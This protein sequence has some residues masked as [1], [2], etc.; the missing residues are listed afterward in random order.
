MKLNEIKIWKLNILDITILFVLLLCLILFFTDKSKATGEIE[1]EQNQVSKFSYQVLIS[2]VSETTGEVIKEGDVLFDKVT[3]APMGTITKI[4]TT[5]AIGFLK[6][7]QGEILAKEIPDKI[8]L[9]LTVETDGN[10]KDGE[11]YANNLVRILVGG[12]KQLKTKYAM[13]IGEVV[14][15]VN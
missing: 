1:S 7:N 5:G 2:G 9:I 8:D 4:E 15:F 6:T 3:S 14:D 11:Y 10:V 13:F 12:S